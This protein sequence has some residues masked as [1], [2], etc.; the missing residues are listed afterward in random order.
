LPGCFGCFPGFSCRYSSLVQYLRKRSF[1][2]P[3][4]FLLP[5]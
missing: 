2:H 3:G 4:G 5:V 1:C